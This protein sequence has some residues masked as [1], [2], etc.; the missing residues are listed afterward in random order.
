MGFVEA[1]FHP[2]EPPRKRAMHSA[3]NPTLARLLGVCGLDRRW[4]RG[5]GV[6]LFDETGRFFLDAYA[7]YG[8]VAL[9]HNP[10]AGVAAMRAALD[11]GDPAMV[12]PYRT[13]DAEALARELVARAPGELAHCLFTTS[14][15]ASVEAAVK[16]VRAGTG[17]PLIVTARGGYHGKTLGTLALHPESRHAEDFGPLRGRVTAAQRPWSHLGGAVEAM[18][19]ELH[20][21]REAA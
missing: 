21:Q 10:P 4:V 15:A 16:L 20:E 6:W 17:R 13:A 3:L 5:S 9:G 11:R 12:Q 8:A 1:S 14:G 7:Q 2:P 18:R 19:Q